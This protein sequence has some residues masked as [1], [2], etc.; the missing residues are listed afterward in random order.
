MPWIDVRSRR[1]EDAWSEV[2][3]T[4]ISDS[5]SGCLSYILSVISLYSVYRKLTKM[6]KHVW[7]PPGR[8]PF[9]TSSWVCLDQTILSSWVL[10][11]QSLSHWWVRNLNHS[12]QLWSTW[13][14]SLRFGFPTCSLTALLI[15]DQNVGDFQLMYLIEAESCVEG[16]CGWPALSFSFCLS[17]ET[18]SFLGCVEAVT[19]SR[20]GTWRSGMGKS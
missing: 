6:L 10:S 15:I 4:L 8:N 19:S 17:V 13:I 9:W 7:I 20:V 14:I 18:T 16:L 12:S 5:K 11:C 2:R 1:M 3:A